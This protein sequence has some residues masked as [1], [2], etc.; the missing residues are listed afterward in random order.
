MTATNTSPGEESTDAE[1][2]SQTSIYDNHPFTFGMWRNAA[3]VT[4]ENDANQTEETD[5]T[6]SKKRKKVVA[7]GGVAV[8]MACPNCDGDLVNVQGVPACTECDWAAK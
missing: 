8:T 4:D 6:E 5:E 3:P 7:D 1:E 2:E